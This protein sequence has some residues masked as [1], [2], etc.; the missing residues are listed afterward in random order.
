MDERKAATCAMACVKNSGTLAA[1]R[2]TQ[3]CV[4]PGTFIRTSIYTQTKPHALIRTH[5]HTRTLAHTH[6]HFCHAG[7]ELTSTAVFH[8]MHAAILAAQTLILQQCGTM[9]TLVLCLVLK[10]KR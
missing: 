9:T 7:A 6:T 3:L 1:Q 2:S 8:E 5:L 4:D 10:V